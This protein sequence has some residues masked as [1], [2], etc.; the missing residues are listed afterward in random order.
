MGTSPTPQ[1][2]ELFAVL[3]VAAVGVMFVLTAVLDAL[4]VRLLRRRVRRA[5][6]RKPPRP[7]TDHGMAVRC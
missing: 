3:L 6:T 1:I 5:P 2:W 4:A 7:G